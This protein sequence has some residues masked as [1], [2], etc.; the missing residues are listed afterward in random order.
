MEWRKVNEDIELEREGVEPLL[1]SYFVYANEVVGI[2]LMPAMTALIM[3]FSA[4]T[5]IPNF[6]GIRDNEMVYYLA[7]S[8]VVIPFSLI[9]DVLILN[10]QELAHGWRV[11]DYIAYQQY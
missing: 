5:M 4:Q 9:M 8:L 7:F 2:C 11:Y 3:V 10:T 1:D 6:Y